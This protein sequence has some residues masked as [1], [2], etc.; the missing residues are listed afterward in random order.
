MAY[1]F[2]SLDSIFNQAENVNK[3]LTVEQKIV[4]STDGAET[5]D[6]Y[7]QHI[8]LHAGLIP[9]QNELSS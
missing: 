5:T 6:I 1:L 8:N 9:L 4:F 3:I 7:V 2:Q